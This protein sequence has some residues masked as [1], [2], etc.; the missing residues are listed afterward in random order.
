MYITKGK[1]KQTEDTKMTI[2]DAMRKYRLPNPTTPEDLECRWSKLLTFGDK[3]VIAGYYYSGQNK[4]CYFGATYEF[5][6][7]DHTC[8][9]TI[10]L[11]AASEVEFEDD[12]HAIAWA[13]QQ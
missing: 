4:P 6:D 7:D 10:G 1:T 9:G 5:L 8:E 12:G 13:M 11:R 3:V 2:N